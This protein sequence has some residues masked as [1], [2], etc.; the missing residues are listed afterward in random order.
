MWAFYE[1]RENNWN[2][3]IQYLVHCIGTHHFE[4]VLLKVALD[5][6]EMGMRT[7]TSIMYRQNI[8]IVS[9]LPTCRSAFGQP[10]F[11]IRHFRFT[12]SPLQA[13]FYTQQFRLSHGNASWNPD[14]NVFEGFYSSSTSVRCYR[15]SL[16]RGRKCKF[17]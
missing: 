10:S 7:R 11:D 8:W 13:K 17:N 14:S 12:L 1:W 16:T 9:R 15:V 3:E 4:M 5:A 2:E 6:L